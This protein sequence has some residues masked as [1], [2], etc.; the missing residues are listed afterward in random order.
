M[1]ST[2]LSLHYHLVFSTKD[3]APV[4]APEWREDLHRYLGA[5]VATAGG[6]PQKVGGVADHVHVLVGLKATHCLA[7]VLQEIKKATSR[8]VHEDVG[9]R[10]FQWQEG[11]GAFTVSE[12]N[13]PR[14]IRYIAQQEAHHRKRPFEDEYL[15][16]LRRHDIQPDPRY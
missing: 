4:L 8:W 9:A 12:S 7:N 13:R 15:D 2:H 10:T 3:R 14:V 16:L 5:C 1:P 6:V 11:Y